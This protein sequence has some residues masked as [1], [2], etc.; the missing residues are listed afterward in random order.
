M[1]KERRVAEGWAAA[2]GGEPRLAD[3]DAA[4]ATAPVPAAAGAGQGPGGTAT[5]ATGEGNGQTSTK[6]G[7]T[8]MG[9]TGE[10]TLAEES[11]GRSTEGPRE[12]CEI[13]LRGAALASRAVADGQL[14]AAAASFQPW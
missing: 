12:E 5:G 1:A 3:A 2:T 7:T 9:G 4:G 14:S 13:E 11:S 6:G 10:T 8:A